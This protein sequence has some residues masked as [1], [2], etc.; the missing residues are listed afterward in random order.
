MSILNK[1]ARLC[2]LENFPE[3]ND[4]ECVVTSIEEGV[5]RGY[6][7][8]L[9]RDGT[10]RKVKRANL[11]EDYRTEARLR[12]E[13]AEI[14]ASYDSDS[15]STISFA[16]EFL[17]LVR[18][19]VTLQSGRK[20]SNAEI[21]PIATNI[22]EHFVERG[23]SGSPETRLPEIGLEDFIASSL[24]IPSPFDADPSFKLGCVLLGQAAT[25]VDER[26]RAAADFSDDADSNRPF[27]PSYEWKGHPATGPFP[28]MNGLELDYA[29]RRCK[30]AD[31][32]NFKFR[33]PSLDK[34]GKVGVISLRLSRLTTLNKVL[35]EMVK[36]G[37][38]P[39]LRARDY[40]NP[41]SLSLFH[42]GVALDLSLTVE[43]AR[44]FHIMKD[45]C[46]EV[47]VEGVA[48][49]AARASPPAA[50]THPPSVPPRANAPTPPRQQQQATMGRT[51]SEETWANYDRLS[52]QLRDV[53]TK[54][55]TAS[56]EFRKARVK[57]DKALNDI[58]ADVAN[59]SG[60]KLDD[61]DRT[62]LK[63]AARELKAKLKVLEEGG[64]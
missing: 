52:A 37:A 7:I 3:L 36:P 55:E 11:V 16:P 27:E 13:L 46:V 40:P 38:W 45:P 32:N 57:A 22:G 8:R 1:R 58:L 47:R 61:V 64:K 23:S 26:R 48:S 6:T 24:R 10:E 9:T 53:E 60:L 44:L 49:D 20:L 29:N 35:E 50:A 18:D 2:R 33:I 19:L 12:S 62:G 51:E 14:F 15:S 39:C 34:V 42:K 30:I 56:E 17:E 41:S 28:C 21:I 25:L 43:Q 4:A 63:S 5:E 31:P 59:D 54:F